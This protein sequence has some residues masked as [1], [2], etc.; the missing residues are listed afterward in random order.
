MEKKEYDCGYYQNN[1]EKILKHQREYQQNNRE[2]INEHVREHCRNNPEKVKENNR[3]YYQNNSEKIKKNSR[4]YYQNNL[5]EVKEHKSKYYRLSRGLPEDADLYKESGIEA[6]VRG[7]LEESDIE[8][9][10]QYF[11]NL[12]NSTWTRVDFYIPEI[13]ACLY[14]DGDYWHSLSE[15]QERD[16]RIN[17]ALEEMGY[18]VIRMTETKILK[19]FLIEDVVAN[20]KHE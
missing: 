16:M 9:E 7:W 6:I 13:N 20:E 3:K 10:Q 18:K 19:G 17:K 11:I 14:T 8:F 15:V 12:E 2:K 4:N 1:V 5:E